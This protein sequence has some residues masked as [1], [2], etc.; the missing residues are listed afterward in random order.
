M[1]TDKAKVSPAQ[2]LHAAT[3]RLKQQ[4]DR[5]QQQELSASHG[6]NVGGLALP[7]LQEGAYRLPPDNGGV[8]PGPIDKK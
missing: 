5:A 7:V 3:L 8:P 6:R 1:S 2:E 4:L